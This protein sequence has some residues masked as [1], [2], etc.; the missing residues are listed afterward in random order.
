MRNE[1]VRN[2]LRVL[3]PEKVDHIACVSNTIYSD[4][5]NGAMRWL[6][7]SG[8]ISLRRHCLGLVAGHQLQDAT[9]F[10]RNE[11]PSLI[12]SVELWVQSGSQRIATETRALIREASKSVERD[13]RNVS[14]ANVT[15][16][17]LR[18]DGI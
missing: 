17:V 8:I 14:V 16:G 6:E 1:K 5:R 7:L 11:I 15:I 13:M 4:N 3:Y 2:N 10:M 12:S 9:H 18:S